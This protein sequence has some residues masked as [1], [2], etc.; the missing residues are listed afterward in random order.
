MSKKL[1]KLMKKL[2]SGDIQE[3]L[4]VADAKLGNAIKVRISS[5]IVAI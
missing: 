3:E 5:Q 1:K 2:Y 4:L